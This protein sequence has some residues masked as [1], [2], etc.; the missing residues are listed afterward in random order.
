MNPATSPITDT[1][2][3]STY[4]VLAPLTTPDHCPSPLA[5]TKTTTVEMVKTRRGL[6]VASQSTQCGCPSCVALQEENAELRAELK[7]T[8]AALEEAQALPFDTQTRLIISHRSHAPPAHCPHRLLLHWLIP[9]RMPAP[10]Q[11]HSQTS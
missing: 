9:I 11:S 7:A 10:I 6:P 8:K 3:I 1:T 5:V 4:I 2:R